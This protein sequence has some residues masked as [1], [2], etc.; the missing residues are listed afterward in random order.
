MVG[1]LCGSRNIRLTVRK[2]SELSAGT[3]LTLTIPSLFI[4][5]LD[6]H[7][8]GGSSLLTLLSGN[9][10]KDRPRDVSLLGH[11]KSMMNCHALTGL[12][13]TMEPGCLRLAANFLGFKLSK[14]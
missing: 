11:F 14:C 1:R 9:A 4:L 2:Q 5:V 7:I 8:Q 6:A 13:L 3:Q 10:L 12:V